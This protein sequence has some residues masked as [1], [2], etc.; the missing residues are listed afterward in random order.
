MK[1][2][3][4]LFS[5]ILVIGINANDL[6]AQSATETTKVVVRAQSK[7]AKFIG[8]SMGGAMITIKNAQTAKLLAQGF[9]V[10]STGDTQKLV[11][12]ASERYVQL[13]SPGAAKFEADLSLSEPTF[14]TIEAVAPY[15]K[16]QA[17][18]TSSTQLWI[19][20]GKDITGDGI[21]LEIPGFSVDVLSPQTHSTLQG[22]QMT[23]RANIVMM[24]G[25]PTSDGGLW[26][27][28]E[29][30][31]EAL[32]KKDGK[33]V[34]TIP[35]NFTGQTS[36]FESMYTAPGQGVYEITVYAYH[37]ETGNTGVDKTTTIVS[38]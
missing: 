31:I 28:S 32:I 36:T 14:V 18:V 7:D 8:T 38:E 27:S 20:P 22:P 5:F 19:I 21:I 16:K 13:S 11:R 23:I 29:Y 12:D 25:C 26:D 15:A 35:L 6:Y 2:V 37:A 1:Y 24:C 4:I 17:H 34:D 33:K 10:G 9:T 30:E 3:P